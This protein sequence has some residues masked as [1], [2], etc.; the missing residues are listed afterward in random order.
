MSL[1][2][3]ISIYIPRESI[4]QVASLSR[5]CCFSRVL[6]THPFFFS[7]DYEKFWDNFGKYLKLGCIEDR[8]NHKRIAPLLRFFSSQSDEEMISL[9]EYVENMKPEQKDIYYIASDSVT[10]AKNTPFLEKLL[11]KDLEVCFHL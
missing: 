9:D 2:R 8:E 6:A 4:P 7:Q 1:P 5:H 10:S 3:L 11:E